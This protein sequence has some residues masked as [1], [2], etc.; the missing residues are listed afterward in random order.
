MYVC[1]RLL[2]YGAQVEDAT[3]GRLSVLEVMMLKNP[4]L[5]KRNLRLLELD[6]ER[7][8]ALTKWNDHEDLFWKWMVGNRCQSQSI[9]YLCTLKPYTHKII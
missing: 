9:K 7:L 1:H 2:L 6:N 8:E 4:D 5:L 3:E